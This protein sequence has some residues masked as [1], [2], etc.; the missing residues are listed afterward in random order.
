MKIFVHR[1][2]QHGFI[3]EGI[4]C[5]FAIKK[6]DGIPNIQLKYQY[7]IE[8]KIRKFFSNGLECSA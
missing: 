6:S 8:L 2:Q 7:L 1:H 5:L 4:K 3:R